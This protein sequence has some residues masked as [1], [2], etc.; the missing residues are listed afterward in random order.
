M[1]GIRFSHNLKKG[2]FA[3][4]TVATWAIQLAFGL[5]YKAIYILGMD[6]G[7]TGKAHFYADK[8][9]PSPDFLQYYEP[10]L[11]GCFQLAQQ[12]SE[13]RGVKLYNLS[14][15][16][17][18]PAEIIPKISFAVALQQITDDALLLK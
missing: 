2:V 1:P 13:K 11:R 7:G 18:L 12:A 4:K 9:N 14:L 6:L 16:S 5:G 17:A 3:G 10:H 8:H 15:Q